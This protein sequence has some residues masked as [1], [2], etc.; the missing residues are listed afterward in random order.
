MGDDDLRFGDVAGGAAGAAA[1][2]FPTLLR[3]LVEAVVLII[4]AHALLQQ[5]QIMFGI[6][7]PF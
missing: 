1:G 2:N 6:H 4:V 5:L 3:W 7:L